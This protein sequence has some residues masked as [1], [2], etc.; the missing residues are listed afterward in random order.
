MYKFILIVGLICQIS[1]NSKEI[2]QA[3]LYKTYQGDVPDSETAISIALGNWLQRYG[4]KIFKSKPFNA[5]LNSDSIWIVSGSLKHITMGGVPY[6]EIRKSD[7]QILKITHE[8]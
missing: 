8:R 7:G 6:A 2:Q 4:R 3:R 1:C 5:K